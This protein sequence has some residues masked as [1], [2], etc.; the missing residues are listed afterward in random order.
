MSLPK[1]FFPNVHL[2]LL[3]SLIALALSLP[4]PFAVVRDPQTHVPYPA[5]PRV[6]PHSQAW[7]GTARLASHPVRARGCSAP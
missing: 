6:S 5:P 1:I 3:D 4:F 7:I 2:L